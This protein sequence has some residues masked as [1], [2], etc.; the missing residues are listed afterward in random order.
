MKAKRRKGETLKQKQA[1]LKSEA[2]L[3][4]EN[5]YHYDLIARATGM[6]DDTL[7][8]YRDEDKE[9]SDELEKSRTRFIHKN[10]KRSRPEFLLERLAKDIFKQATEQDVKVEMPAPIMEVGDVQRNNSNA[11]DKGADQKV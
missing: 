3:N 11:K 2:V 10:M 7:K 1:R 9:F 6:T 4:A 8:K 5:F